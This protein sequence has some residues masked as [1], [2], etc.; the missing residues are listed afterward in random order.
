MFIMNYL[1]ETKYLPQV[2][3]N[4]T[5]LK[6]L[7]RGRIQLFPINDLVARHE[8]INNFSHQAS[9]FCRSKTPMYEVT[10][11]LMISKN[12]PEASH[13]LSKFAEGMSI[14]RDKGTYEQIIK[15]YQ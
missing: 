7:L 15:R 11:H 8:I 12:N 4:T 9:E 1:N 6:Q 13:I 14:I 2:K 10:L 3:D 5:A